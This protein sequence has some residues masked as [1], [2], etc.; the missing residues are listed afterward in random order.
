[1]VEPRR[2]IHLQSKIKVMEPSADQQQDSDVLPD[3]EGRCGELS[4]YPSS[5]NFFS[6]PSRCPF[7]M[8]SLALMTATVAS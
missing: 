6:K 3:Q 7:T 1:M 5:N 8:A 4:A 2:P